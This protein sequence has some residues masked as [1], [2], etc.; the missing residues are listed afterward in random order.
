MSVGFGRGKG[1]NQSRTRESFKKR[2]DVVE[3]KNPGGQS[4]VDNR[5]RCEIGKKKK[6]RPRLYNMENSGKMQTIR[7]K[8]KEKFRRDIFV[9]YRK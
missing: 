8:E 1:Q 2:D 5:G 3:V 4:Y 9:C 7:L 6:P